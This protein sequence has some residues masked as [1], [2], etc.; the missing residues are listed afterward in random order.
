MTEQPPGMPAGIPLEM[1]LPKA[2][3][4]SESEFRRERD[5]DHLR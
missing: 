1:S 4:V 5:V 3:F 2:S